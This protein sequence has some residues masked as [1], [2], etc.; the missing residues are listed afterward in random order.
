MRG[1]LRAPVLLA[2]ALL[3]SQGAVSWG[4]PL[5]RNG[6]IK[7][8]LRTYGN[9]RIGT[10]STDHH[11]ITR[12][13]ASVSGDRV[14]NSETFPYS[15]KGHIRQNRYFAEVDFDHSL[16]RLV[17]EGFG[18]FVLFRQL[19]FQL[20]GLK[21]HLTFRGEAD[22][23]YDWGPRE[24]R[25]AKEYKTG[26]G[27]DILNV[28]LPDNPISGRR[29]DVLA[30]RRRLRK[31]M[32][33]RERLFQAFVEGNVGDFFWRFGRQSLSW[34]ES[35]G[36]R[37][38]DNINP[39][40]S[41]FGGFLISLDERRVPLDMLRVDYFLGGVGPI[42]EAF[43]ELYAAIDD[44]VSW[45]PGAISGSPWTFPNLD[46]PSALVK[47]DSK[48]PSR[49]L[50]DTRGGG[51]VVWNMYGGTFSVAH[52]YTYLDLPRLYVEVRPNF[53]L[54]AFEDGYLAVTRLRAPHSR[55]TGGTAT[56]AF[57]YEWAQLLRLSGEPIIR[58]EY[59]HIE[60]EPRYRQEKIDPFVF[61][62]LGGQNR[63]RLSGGDLG[64]SEN[65]VIGLD[66]NQFLR[67]LN[68][69]QSFLISTQFFY[70]HL[71]NAAGREHI[72]EERFPF[73]LTGEVLPIP[74][75]LVSGVIDIGTPIEPV[76]VQNPT[77]Q[78]LQTFLVTT[79]YRSG[80]I[81]PYFAMFYD[82]EGAL[83]FQPGLTL[84]YDPFRI[85]I[86]YSHLTAGTLKGGSGVS[87]LRD[88]DN[89]QFRVEYV[90]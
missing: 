12:E 11:E 86:D 44:E 55:I 26:S 70:K 19:P 73:L 13:E 50:K 72:N 18:P 49:S 14:T 43:V 32:V 20:H 22:G 57:P 52:Y 81:S 58:A 65:L 28:E 71:N 25:T 62:S 7:L 74:N 63:R 23:I 77:D 87:L 17:K 53:P 80:T 85:G 1:K 51:R 89:V 24:Y 42:S 45:S 10:E 3:L 9:V 59:A 4:A 39:L 64:S 16:D 38:L 36:F 75:R 67:W 8:G 47:V 48:K 56:F 68:P 30:E 2:A 60:R 29:V 66:M 69:G 41:S 5:D 46:K 82:W 88:R 61:H 15:K 37:L 83:V 21:Y 84:T 54:A 34:G 78:F 35:D 40:D 31:H 6:E 33:H 76:F 79:S 27:M 90:I